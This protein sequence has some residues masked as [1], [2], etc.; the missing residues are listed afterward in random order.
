MQAFDDAYAQLARKVRLGCATPSAS[1]TDVRNGVKD[2]LE[3]NPDWLMVVDNADTYVD[4]FGGVDEQTDYTIRNALPLPRP[5][6]AML[7]YTS[8]H[9]RLAEDLT[10]HHELSIKNLSINDSKTLLYNKLGTLVEDELATTLLEA[11]GY[12]P[13]SIAHAAAYLKFTKISIQEY[14]DRV[15]N[16]ADLLELLD[17][18]SV[19][20]GRR[21]DRASRSVVKV[22]LTTLDLLALHNEHAASLLAFMACMNRQSIAAAVV[23]LAIGE[24]M[25]RQRQEYAIELPTSRTE[26]DSAIGEL[27]SLALISR[28]DEGQSFSMHRHVQAIVTQRMSAS[29]TRTVNLLLCA[30]C[31][32]ESYF[33]GVS[34]LLVEHHDG[35]PLSGQQ[36]APKIE[37]AYKPLANHPRGYRVGLLF[38]RTRGI[39]SHTRQQS[40][41]TSVDQIACLKYICSSPLLALLAAARV[42]IGLFGTQ[43]PSESQAVR[44]MA[45]LHAAGSFIQLEKVAL[46]TIEQS[47]THSVCMVAAKFYLARAV[48]NIRNLPNRNAVTKRSVDDLMREASEEADAIQSEQDDSASKFDFLTL[49][50]DT[51]VSAGDFAKAIKVQERLCEHLSNMFGPKDLQTLDVRMRLAELKGARSVASEELRELEH[52]LQKA[53]DSMHHSRELTSSDDRRALIANNL[54][55]RVKVLS[56]RKMQRT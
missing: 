49:L 54:L 56:C 44:Y 25:T 52:D 1:K 41:N 50:I 12:L 42:A 7:V 39:F 23:R 46:D 2:W 21:D 16:D 47:A 29:R 20:V 48:A 3:D 30:R 34:A 37:Q 15:K 32:L 13:M 26:L 40:T 35:H 55:S 9:A 33:P 19:N 43:S 11:L 53:C 28:H 17:S 6:S 38:F 51:Y 10:E 14:L 45:D 31:V 22:L 18:Q 4:F 24:R 36:S 8:R 27:E 5:G